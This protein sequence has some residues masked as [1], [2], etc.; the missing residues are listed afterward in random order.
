MELNTVYN[1]D[2]LEGMKR[3]PSGS[4]DLILCDPPYG[5]MKGAAL[6]GWSKD[7][8]SWDT[9]IDNEEL[10]NEYNRILR[11]NGLIV[12]FS[13]EPFTSKLRTHHHENIQFAYP[14][15][16]RKNHFANALLAKKAPVN[17]IE[18]IS[19]FYKKYD[20]EGV[21]PLR[22][23]FRNVHSW[24]GKT[25]KEIVQQVGQC[26][27]HTFRYNSLQFKMCTEETYSKL[28][29]LYN[30]EEF[31]GFLNYQNLLEIKSNFDRVFNLPQ[32]ARFK[33]NVFEFKKD[34]KGFHPT[35][36]PVRLIED[37]IETFS[38]EKDIVLDNCMG[39]GTTAIACINTNRKYIGFEMDEEY[40]RLLTKRIEEH[41]NVLV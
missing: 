9:V 13:Q 31:T 21:H 2:C 14:M 30:L 19:V 8:L 15:F 33:S 23:Y 29:N 32:G 39:S 6:D 12:L 38:N 1:E 7:N 22:E 41:T 3:I 16:W 40:H 20:S 27:D 17:Y 35:Q 28:T 10:F 37:I 25:K 34:S 24:I 11:E 26:T 5:T 36:K 4:V 18:D